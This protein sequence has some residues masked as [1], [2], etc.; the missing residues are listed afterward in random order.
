MGITLSL[1]FNQGRMG[2]QLDGAEV[3][4]FQDQFCL[5]LCFSLFLLRLF[6]LHWLL[7]LQSILLHW[8]TME[9]P[10]VTEFSHGYPAFWHGKG[11][12]H[13]Q[14]LCLR[15]VQL[16]YICACVPVCVCV[17]VCVQKILRLQSKF[18]ACVELHVACRPLVA[19]CLF[20][21]FFFPLFSYKYRWYIFLKFVLLLY[22]INYG[23]RSRVRT[24]VAS[25]FSCLHAT[26]WAL[27]FTGFDSCLP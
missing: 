5:G 11:C 21:F 4:R 26:C 1:W 18:M 10:F 22:G 9:V 23:L 14:G 8:K 13:L 20:L 24:K 17:C 25:F 12:C 2:G 19:F 7:N 16:S 27:W 15:Q 6:S 3:F